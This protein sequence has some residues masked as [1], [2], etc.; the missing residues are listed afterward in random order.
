[1]YLS[2]YEVPAAPPQVEEVAP[3]IAQHGEATHRQAD[4]HNEMR[5]P[6]TRWRERLGGCDSLQCTSVLSAGEKGIV[7]M[8][9]CS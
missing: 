4:G 8:Q 5:A 3:H 2:A 7:T 6:Q 1:M 9:A